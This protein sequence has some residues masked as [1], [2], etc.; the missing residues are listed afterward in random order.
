[1]S[2]TDAELTEEEKVEAGMMLGEIVALARAVNVDAVRELA[3]ISGRFDT[4]TSIFDPTRWIREH[5]A[6]EAASRVAGA[7]LAFRRVIDAEAQ[8]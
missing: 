5:A 6:V 1:M 2:L 4:V 8:E 7:F 3:Q